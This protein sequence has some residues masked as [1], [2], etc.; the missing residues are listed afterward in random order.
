MATRTANAVWRGSLKGGQGQLAFGE[1]SAAYQADYGFVSRFEEG[2]GTNPEELLGAAHA[3]CFSMALAAGLGRAGYE[4]NQIRTRATVTLE[5]VEGAQTIVRVTLSTEA[6]VPG[7]G[8]DE[9]LAQAED[10]KDNCPVSRALT[11][12]EVVLDASLTG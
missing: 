12:V 1:G 11:G 6:E 4:P 3:A 7:I 10:A 5:K 8:A 2:P 9:F